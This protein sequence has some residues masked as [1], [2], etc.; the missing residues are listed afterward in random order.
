MPKTPAGRPVGPWGGN[1]RTR[2]AILTSALAIID[3]DG[4]EGLSMRRLGKALGRDPMILYRHAPNKAALLD[5]V[6]EIVLGQLSVDPR[7][8]TGKINYERWQGISVDWL[9]T[10]RTWFRCWS[11]APWPRPSRC[12]RSE[13][14]VPS[15]VS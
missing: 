13:L 5:G 1:I 4:V 10:T 14:C 11:P 15:K 9:S 3:R 7:A 12:V 6:A 8:V 2:E